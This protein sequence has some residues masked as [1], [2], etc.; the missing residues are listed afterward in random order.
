[1]FTTCNYQ[2]IR[3]N[4]TTESLAK[5]DK[6]RQAPVFLRYPKEVKTHHK[7]YNLLIK[8]SHNDNLTITIH[9]QMPKKILNFKFCQ[10]KLV[11]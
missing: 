10:L 9:I 5:L 11:R 6:T 8:N 2:I 1:M 7:G 4:L 3:W